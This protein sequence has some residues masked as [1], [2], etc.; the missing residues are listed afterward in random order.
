MQKVIDITPRCLAY[1]E[2]CHLPIHAASEENSEIVLHVPFLAQ[3][4]MK[5]DILEYDKHGGLLIN[6][7][8]LYITLHNLFGYSY[9]FRDPK[10]LRIIKILIQSN[11]L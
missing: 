6:D 8:K 1:I 7:V 9:I 3:E 4:A 5:H 11:I 2:N 10:Y